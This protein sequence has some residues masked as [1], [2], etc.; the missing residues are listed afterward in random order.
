[1]FFQ[2]LNNAG[3]HC[4]LFCG[5]HR[6]FLL[7]RLHRTLTDRGRERAAAVPPRTTAAEPNPSFFCLLTQFI[8]AANFSSQLK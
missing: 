6:V 4:A 2:A 8:I 3:V 5:E 1:M 7:I